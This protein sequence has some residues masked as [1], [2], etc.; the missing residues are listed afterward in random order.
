MKIENMFVKSD[1]N[2][3]KKTL[4]KLDLHEIIDEVTYESKEDEGSHIDKIRG[5]HIEDNII[6]E[7]QDE[8]NNI[9]T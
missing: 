1:S 7:I 6:K 5:A 4:K 9:D 2:D 8:L 3:S